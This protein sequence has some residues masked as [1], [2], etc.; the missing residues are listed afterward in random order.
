M[1]AFIRGNLATAVCIAV[2]F[3]L[4]FDS[5][6]AVGSGELTLG[7]DGRSDYQIVVPDSYPA[8]NIRAAVNRA[9]NLLRQTFGENGMEIAVVEES[10]MKS[11][12]PAIFLGATRFARDNG[13]PFGELEGWEYVFKVVGKDVIIAGNDAEDPMPLELRR[14][15]EARG[16]GIP[17]FGTLKAVTDFVY[18]YGGV[19]FLFPGQLG[20]EFLPTPTISVPAD[21][22]VRF[23]PYGQNIEV[24]RNNDL[25]LFANGMEPMPLVF[26]NYGHFHG[27]AIR[28][29]EYG[30][31]NPEY[32]IFHSNQRD[33]RGIHLCF[34][35]PEVREIIYQKVLELCDI[36]YDII[37]MGQNDGFRAC[38][39][40]ECHNL[41]GVYP[42]T[43]PEQGS[44]FLRDPAW[45]EKLWIMHR[46]MA[47]RLKEDRPGKKLMICA[48]S[49]AR[50]A[51]TTFDS[52][53][54]NVIVQMMHANPEI[55]DEWS[56]IDV[57]GGFAAYTYTWG[58]I[59]PR[60]SVRHIEEQIQTLVDNDIRAIQN[61]LK[62]RAYGLEGPNVYVFRRMINNPHGKTADE[63]Y[64]EYID[65]AYGRAAGFMHQ[66]FRRLN[67]RL[68]H[69][70][71]AEQYGSSSRDPLLMLNMI[72]TPDLMN[73][74]DGL[75]TRAENVATDPKVKARLEGTRV[76]FDNLMHYSRIIQLYYAYL[77][78]PDED[79]L[80][81]VLTAVD[82]RNAWLEFVTAGGPDAPNLLVAAGLLRS[83]GGGAPVGL[84]PFNW[85]TAEMRASE[86]PW[87]EAKSPS[88]TVYRA[89]GPVD[90]HSS[91]WKDVPA[92]KLNPP[93]G[94]RA[95][96]HETTTFQLMYD[97]ENLYVRVRG[98]MQP[99]LM[100]TFS[101]RGRDGELWL[102]ECINI[103]LAPEGD[104]SQYYY[105]T[106]EP[107]E[108][109]FIDANHGFIT[110]PLHPAYGWNDQTWDGDWSY[111]NDLRPGEAV[112]LSMATIPFAT[113]E[114]QRPSSGTVWAG[115]IGRIHY[116]TVPPTTVHR[117]MVA[118]R[119]TSVWTGLLNASRN[120]GDAYMGDWVF[121]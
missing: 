45:G 16:G 103:L 98:G 114:A 53:P 9:A 54:D 104:R 20:L 3:C 25:Y 75:L 106:Y 22:N 96:L 41:Y 85:N 67:Q 38:G 71:T 107:V 82:N 121:E 34:S 99:E 101:P 2:A 118:S 51:P 30:D 19:R 17:F 58:R 110:D 11:G 62:P 35:N 65:A 117:D 89:T 100:D 72:Y 86:R 37:E 10:A 15:R 80:E 55:F 23:R 78:Q 108:N 81:R 28:P 47:L 32:F 90:L 97:D 31:S 52:L 1:T 112:W 120:F 21:L 44:A 43:V 59:L 69:I 29:E 76:E 92:T 84:E 26:S 61:N 33:N 119:E 111:V 94:S 63:L 48:Y 50:P 46:D 109:S 95:E 13:V 39:C 7:S 56:R 93:R 74:L 5:Q 40:E 18:E 27:Q 102:Q 115:N 68:D 105:L 79:S 14:H 57:P 70:K 88:V 66:F 113:V 36:G 60:N 49:V 73:T 77:A 116:F 4:T 87:E 91:Q 42:T 83:G 8:D 12:S 64:S 24:P 6:A